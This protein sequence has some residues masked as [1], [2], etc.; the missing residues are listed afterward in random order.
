MEQYPITYYRRPHITLS[1]WGY[2]TRSIGAPKGLTRHWWTEMPL[3]KREISDFWYNGIT[4]Q[5]IMLLY[6]VQRNQQTGDQLF[7]VQWNQ[8][9][10]DYAVISGTI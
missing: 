3:I 7:L 4:K 5:E 8:Q 9:T 10:G 2:N 6:L 1:L